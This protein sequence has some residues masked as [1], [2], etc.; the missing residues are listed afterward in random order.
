MIASSYKGQSVI[1][2]PGILQNS[3]SKFES[4]RILLP[5][6]KLRNMI[7]IKPVGIS[8]KTRSG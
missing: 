6:R 7:K 2:Y 5:V 4:V 8:S 3:I 1:K